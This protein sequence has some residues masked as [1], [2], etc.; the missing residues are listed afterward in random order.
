LAPGGEAIIEIDEGFVRERHGYSRRNT[1]R[2]LEIVTQNREFLL[3]EWRK[4]HG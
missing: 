2:A 3:A 4:I 1:A